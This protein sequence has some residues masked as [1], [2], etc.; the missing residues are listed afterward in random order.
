MPKGHKKELN[1]VAGL[2]EMD[3][4]LAYAMRKNMG[5]AERILVSSAGEEDKA[6]LR[7]Y[8]ESHPL[9]RKKPSAPSMKP[10]PRVLSERERILERVA[11][12]LTGLS[13]PNLRNLYELAKSMGRV[14]RS[15]VKAALPRTPRQGGDAGKDG[16]TNLK[17]EGSASAAEAIDGG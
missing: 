4:A 1:L 11:R 2:V 6:A 7:A 8:L 9:S 17:G 10:A 3:R 15:R 5:T 12:V 13:E 14:E 16:R